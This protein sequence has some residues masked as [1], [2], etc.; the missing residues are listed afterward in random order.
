VKSK[1]KIIT[2]SLNKKLPSDKKKKTDGININEMVKGIKIATELGF[3]VV[4]PLVAGAFLGSYL[5]RN[6][7]TS[8]KLTLLFILIGLFLSLFSMYKIVKDSF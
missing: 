7:K 1:S 4:I 5:D 6:L 3:S 8:P 2:D